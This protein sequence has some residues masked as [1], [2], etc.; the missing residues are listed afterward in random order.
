M[1]IHRSV[2]TLKRAYGR[3]QHLFVHH[4]WPEGPSRVVAKVD[5]YTDKGICPI[6]GTH[7]V[8]DDG[9]SRH[10]LTHVFLQTCYQNP[11]AVWPD[12]D[13]IGAAPGPATIFHVIDRNQDQTTD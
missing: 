10:S 5:W 9:E 8:A 2:R 6:A 13:S 7:L 1:N 12:G 3:I 11:V 4:M